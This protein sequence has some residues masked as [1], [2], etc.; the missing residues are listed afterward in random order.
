MADEVEA[1]G[2]GTGGDAGAATRH[3]RAGEIDAGSFEQA[4]QALSRQQRFV[5]RVGQLV[6]RQVEAA[7]NAS[8]SSTR[9]ALDDA[10]GEARCGAGIEHL[11]FLARQVG[12]DLRLVAYQPA[13]EARA[14]AARLRRRGR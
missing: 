9:P 5:G 4:A 12:A 13:I 3:H 6:V 7:G 2:E 8:G 1:E 10:A 14:E 11:L